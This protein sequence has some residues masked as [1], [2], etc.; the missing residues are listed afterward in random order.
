MLKK[1]VRILWRMFLFAV[2]YIVV[3]VVLFK[4][5]SVGYT[6]TMFARS[7]E[8][9]FAGK[10]ATIHY[11][12]VSYDD[13]SDAPKLAVVASEDQ[14]FPTHEGI[15]WKAL[16]IALKQG[17]GGSTISQQVAKNVFLWQGIG[18]DRYLRKLLEVPITYLIEWVWGKQRILE[19]Y[20]NVIEVGPQT[21]G[22]Q[23]AAKRYFK[24][25]A[26]KLT[27]H[28]AALIA[29]VLPSPRKWLIV[30][31]IARVLAR[32]QHTMYQM[33][34]LGGMSYLKNMRKF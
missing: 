14:R 9:L 1:L 31:P 11:E 12:W 22:V 17:R 20:L 6:P 7:M 5:I 24:K 19:V 28:E 15:D 30:R 23:Q 3:M 26:K 10:D 18:K 2:I 8:A 4:F 27:V 32:Q 25:N 21:F 29:A 33:R 34:L 13:I 16:K